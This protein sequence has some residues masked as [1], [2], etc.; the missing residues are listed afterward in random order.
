MNVDLLRRVCEAPGAPGFE[1][2]IRDLL[3]DEVEPLVD[4]IRVDNIGNVI[5]YVEGKDT[6]KTVM[7][8]AH[9]DEIGFMVRHI[10]DRGF[11]KFLP[12]GGFDPKTLTAQRVIVHGKKD[13]VGVM[14]VKPIHVM[15]AAE[16]AKMPEL[17]DTI[18]T[19]A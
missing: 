4:S 11:I 13:L 7:V 12:L 9:M 5:A 2:A 18:S 3:I 16:R 10:D 6:T 19:L 8:A 14:G 17:G 15:T 1:H